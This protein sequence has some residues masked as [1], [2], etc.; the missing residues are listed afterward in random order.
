M[1]NDYTRT[2]LHS[3]MINVLDIKMK[4]KRVSSKSTPWQHIF[5]PLKNKSIIIILK[6]F[7]FGFIRTV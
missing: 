7:F 1:I 5:S 4:S 3:H 6:V 2:M